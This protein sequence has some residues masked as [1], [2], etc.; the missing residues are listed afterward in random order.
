MFNFR[1]IQIPSVTAITAAILLIA[2]CGGGGGGGGAS[3][4][5]PTLPVDAVAFNSANAIDG[6]DVALN[7]A[8]SLL[9]AASARGTNASFTVQDAFD[10]VTAR[11][12]NRAKNSQPV[13]TR[14]TTTTGCFVSGTVTET[15]NATATGGTGTMAFSN[16]NMDGISIINGSFSFIVA[17]NDPIVDF[18]FGGSLTFT[19][20]ADPSVVVS[21]VMNSSQT[22]N[23]TTFTFTISQT[24]SASE[25]PIGA[26][27][28]GFL[29]TTIVPLELD[30]VSGVVSGQLLIQGAN[31]SQ[32]RFTV[33]ALNVATV[34]VDDG[35]G[36]GF[37]VVTTS[38]AI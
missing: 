7:S 13:A 9:T 11:V 30:F 26:S 18:D 14:D 25:I 23:T 1:S 33:T 28:G 16:C 37:V 8:G 36:G 19:L 17:I 22:I 4:P 12:L 10:L 29:V 6:T 35:V 31:G 32:I 2:G 27:T 3:F 5:T 24:Y 38:Y 20:V 21:M 15:G 34:E